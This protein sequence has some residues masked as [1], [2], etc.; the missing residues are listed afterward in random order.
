MNSSLSEVFLR[1][2]RR[3]AGLMLPIL[4]SVGLI[5]APAA[6]GATGSFRTTDGIE[7]VYEEHGSG[8]TLVF[9][10]GW[11]MPG[12]AWR[13]QVNAFKGRHRVIVLDPR[14]QGHSQV[15][16][17]GM[18]TER[19]AKDIAELMDH[20]GVRRTILIGWSMGV[21]EVLSYQQQFG[22]GRLAGLVLVDG[23]VGA[24][25]AELLPGA[26]AWA[27]GLLTNQGEWSRAFV[28]SMFCGAPDAALRDQLLTSSLRM[29][30]VAGFALLADYATTDMSKVLQSVDVPVL[31][32]GTHAMESQLSLVR[33]VRPSA[34]VIEQAGCHVFFA[35]QPDAF[36]DVLQRFIEAIGAD[37]DASH[38]Q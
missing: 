25:S 3:V 1:A 5:G 12:S 37:R 4:L 9:V 23:M 35:E 7:L 14:S 29:P 20:V 17:D 16:S 28:G 27:R 15:T 2:S 38:S 34:Q 33:T 13:Q 36:N 31:Y 26:F 21:K 10:P 32:F 11:G 19:R 8:S 24:G 30:P 18:Y 22:S 6:H